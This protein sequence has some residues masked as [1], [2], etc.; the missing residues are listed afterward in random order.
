ML[1]TPATGLRSGYLGVRLMQPNKRSIVLCWQLRAAADG[2]AA[3][4]SLAAPLAGS[5]L[6]A[7]P[8]RH[9]RYGYDSK[10][11]SGLYCSADVAAAYLT[12]VG[13]RAGWR[14]GSGRH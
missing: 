14:G 8:G 10:Y 3:E 6:R 13:V 7:A 1:L 11:W 2:M 12:F 4:P 9:N 5:V